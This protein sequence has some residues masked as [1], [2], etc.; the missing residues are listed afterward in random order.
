MYKIEQQNI[1]VDQFDQLKQKLAGNDLSWLR[2]IR[3]SSIAKFA[4]LGFPTLR[5]EEWR[6]TNVKPI[7]DT[8]FRIDADGY[9]LEPSAAEKIKQI[10]SQFGQLSL[11]QIVFI[12]GRYSSQ[13]S[14]IPALPNQIQVASLAQILKTESANV[15]SHLAQYAHFQEYSF[16]ALNTAFFPDGAFVRIPPATVA[17]V[18]IHL[19]FISSPD[20]QPVVTHP[21]ILVVAEQNS[22][23]TVIETYI[24]MENEVYWVNTVTELV[25]GE[26]ST[27][28]HCKIEMESKQAFHTSLLQ[29]QQETNS[30]VVCNSISL[31]GRIVRNDLNVLLNGEGTDCTLNGLYHVTGNQHVD[32]HTT[33]DHIKPHGTSREL[34][35]G[36]LDGQSR[37]VFNGRIIVHPDAQ[38]TDAIQVNKNLLLSN[39]GLVNTKPELK[40]FAN[41][42]KCKHGATVGQIDSDTLFYLRSRGIDEKSARQILITAFANGMIDRIS[43]K[44]LQEI[45]RTIEGDNL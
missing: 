43:S 40:I 6:F 15:E 1:Y 17:D 29:I 42:V 34:Y 2:Q 31:G 27:I 32:N 39:E 22:K 18:P 16:T 13:F 26:N 24:G 19:L 23:A 5:N 10:V 25:A 38:K 30:T 3:Q 37:A 44:P 7:A 12:N 45:V 33:I 4:D 21:R 9:K 28:E 35:K 20:S 14:S 11:C 36:I 8:P 41:D